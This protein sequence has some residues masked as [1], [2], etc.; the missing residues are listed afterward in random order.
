MSPDVTIYFGQLACRLDWSPSLH[1]FSLVPTTVSQSRF[2]RSHRHSRTQ[3]ALSNAAD[4]TVWA[5]R[6]KP[7]SATQGLTVGKGRP[8]LGLRDPHGVSIPPQVP[9]TCSFFCPH[10]PSF[11]QVLFVIPAL[12]L[13]SPSS[14]KPP[15]LP[16][17]SSAQPRGVRD[18]ASILCLAL[19]GGYTDEYI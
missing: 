17:L 5:G 9:C 11:G 13:M 12:A 14:G 3:S 2:F 18:T 19:G 10:G 8:G 1:P 15:F 16:Q 7:S 4:V 6:C